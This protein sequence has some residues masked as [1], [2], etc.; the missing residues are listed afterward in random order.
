[1]VFRDVSLMWSWQP[2]EVKPLVVPT[3]KIPRSTQRGCLGIRRLPK[4][5]QVVADEGG[6][7]QTN[8]IHRTWLDSPEKLTRKAPESHDGWKIFYI[9]SFPVKGPFE[10]KSGIKN[11]LNFKGDVT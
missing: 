1:M 9:F 4:M 3:C 7:K 11:P 10:K 6:F 5:C 8:K 2:L